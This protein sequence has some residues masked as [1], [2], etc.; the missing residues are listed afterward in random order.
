MGG[1][2]QILWI[3][4]LKGR[5]VTAPLDIL[6]VG[7]EGY[8]STGYPGRKEGGSQLHWISWL[9]GRR[10]TAP[11]DILAEVEEGNSATGYPG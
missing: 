1:G 9:K 3:S 8:S 2:L 7:E 11:K 10:I 6:A 4:W 5:R